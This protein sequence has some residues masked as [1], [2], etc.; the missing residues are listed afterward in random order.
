MLQKGASKRVAEGVSEAWVKHY[1][2]CLVNSNDRMTALAVDSSGNVYV[3]GYSYDTMSNYDYA[4]IKYNSSGE[5]LWVAR[6]NGLGN[7]SDYARAIALD[8]SGNVYVTGDNEILW[9]ALRCITTIK[10][11]EEANYVKE[12][13]IGI[14]D[15]YRLIQNYPN[16]FNST[17]TIEF[18][19]PK[20]TEVELK[21]FDVLGR[22]V[23]ELVNGKIKAGKYRVE[24][25]GDNLE[26]GV[27]LYRLKPDGYVETKKLILLK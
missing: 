21:V 23:C 2:S 4:T 11:R 26:S 15:N 12:E 17:T 14:P 5:V 16:P 20:D 22:E 8:A 6:Y 7:G 25:N 10:Y 19:I 9:E 27:Y 13:L 1:G 24:W 18:S 3:T